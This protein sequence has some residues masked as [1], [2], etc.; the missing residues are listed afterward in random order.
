MVSVDEAVI[1]RLD[2]HGQ[3]FEIMVDPE[4]ALDVKK[5]E[6]VPLR[7]LVAVEEVYEDSDKG[8]RVSDEDL[9]QVFGTNDFQ[10]IAYKIIRKGEVQLTTEQRRDMRQEKRKEIASIISRRA[11]NPQTDNPHPQKRILNAMEEAGVHVDEMEDAENQ[12]SDVIDKLR[13]II[14]ISIETKKVAVKVPPEF[15][16]KASG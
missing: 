16:G 10:E 12:V 4:K 9:N 6:D 1:A 2:S 14:P 5:G 8:K 7:D 15:A 3:H 13:P 11:V